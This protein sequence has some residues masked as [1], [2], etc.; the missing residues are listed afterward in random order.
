M[1]QTFFE[2]HYPPKTRFA[3]IERLLSFIK[4]GK[5][6]QLVALPGV[7][8]STLL[9]L[10]A[11][12][13]SV[14]ELHLGTERKA[15]HFVLVNFSE[16]RKKPLG[17]VTKFLFLSLIDSLKQREMSEEYERVNTVFKDHLQHNDDL[18]L[19]QGLK[20]AFDYLALEKN[21][22]TIFL[23]DRFEEYIP[24]VTEDFFAQLRVLRN[25]AKYRFAVVFSLHRPLE[26]TLEPALMTDYYDFIAGNTIYIALSDEVGMNFRKK[27][28]EKLSHNTIDPAPYSQIHTLTGGFPR[29][30]KECL[31]AVFAHD[32]RTFSSIEEL[33]TYVLSQ[34]NVQRPLYEI[35]LSLTP[36]EQD[37]LLSKTTYETQDIDYPYLANVGLLKD[38]KITIPLFEHFLRQTLQK[39]DQQKEN[40]IIT[41]D[42][43]TNEIKKGSLVLS[44]QLT[45]SE[46]RLLRYL[47]ENPDKI[48]DREEIIH[49]VWKE[50]VSTIG[51]TDQ[52]LD[53]LIFRVRRKIEEDPNN[54]AHLQTIKG[55]GIRFTT[56]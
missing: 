29:I 8:R 1:E 10:L 53:Q 45:R 28:F 41:Y 17:D 19:E 5:S 35:W 25:R 24:Q 38:G 56:K 39:E 32:N 22:T 52:A 18:V 11:Y 37:F 54:P 33:A 50:S 13:K 23:L 14:R 26:E 47:L 15:F 4:Q 36:S 46:F 44:E 43:N 48:I 30:I 40:D 6:C 51:V 27:H 34:R 16:V 49:A 12:N 20:H 21:L 3:E 9:K 55:R 31:E 2:A 7:G 42:Q